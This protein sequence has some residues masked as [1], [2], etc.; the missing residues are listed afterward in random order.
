MNLAEIKKLNLPPTSG[1]YQFF[2]KSG[3]IIYIGKAANLKNRVLSYWQKSAGLT[4][5]KETMLKQIAKIRWLE[6]ESEIEALLLESNLVK[7]YQPPY[8]IVLR[9]DKRFAYVKISLADEIP[10]VF[11]TRTVDK[12]GKYFGPF[13]SALAARETIR[14]LRK[15]F[16][17]CNVKK[18]QTR[19]C[20]YYQIG[21]CLGVC[22]GK[23]G[24]EEYVKR[25]IKPLELFLQGKKKSIIKN[26]EVRS[27]KLELDKNIKLLGWQNNLED[28]YGQADV[29]ILT[30]DSEGW[31]LAVIEAASFGL[32]IIMTDTGCAGEVIK[33]GESGLVIPIGDKPELA[34]AMLKI[35]EDGNLRKRLGEN[36]KL[37]AERLPNKEQTLALYKKSWQIAKDSNYWYN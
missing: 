17:Y 21:R 32:P 4:P 35:I 15:I 2:N 11:L 27:K 13:T 1:C 30:S 37:A 8:N 7:K 16:P 36:A 25:V 18:A 14:A 28:Y 5:A 6:T 19:P 31:G 33:T 10:G 29:F 34:A 12:A 24:R 23:I 26:L 3:S 22:A 20:F 9:D